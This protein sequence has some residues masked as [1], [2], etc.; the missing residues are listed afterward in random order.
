MMRSLQV[1]NCL[2]VT[3]DLKFT[4]KAELEA[5]FDIVANT[6]SLLNNMSFCSFAFVL[7]K[8]NV[9]GQVL[10]ECSKNVVGSKV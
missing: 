7:L 9:L 3:L 4:C 2:L 6:K 10:L 5:N 8:S 1:Q